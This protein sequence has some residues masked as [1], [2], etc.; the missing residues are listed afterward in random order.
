[1]LME[2]T[3]FLLTIRWIFGRFCLLYIEVILV[4]SGSSIVFISLSI[5]HKKV[6]VYV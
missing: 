2:R 5:R 1:M 3:L 6:L 4:G